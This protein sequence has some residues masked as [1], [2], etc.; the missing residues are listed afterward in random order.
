[1]LKL[2]TNKLFLVAIASSLIVGC[3]KTT[4]GDRHDGSPFFGVLMA[5]LFFVGLPLALLGVSIWW[6]YRH[7]WYYWRGNDVGTFSAR[8]LHQLYKEGKIDSQTPIRQVKDDGWNTGV[9]IEEAPR[10]I[11]WGVRFALL[12]ALFAFPV[13][14][15]VFGQVRGL[16]GNSRGLKLEHLLVSPGKYDLIALSGLTEEQLRQVALTRL[17]LEVGAAV[18]NPLSSGAER[19]GDR[20]DQQWDGFLERVDAARRRVWTIWALLVLIGG[21][22]GAA[23]AKGPVKVLKEGRVVTKNRGATPESK[24]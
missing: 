18:P 19:L 8:Q 17:G 14:L 11:R 21:S 20:M 24:P 16:D 15:L 22:I 2:Q 13:G 3:G 9:T 10:R 6:R 1:M 5:L 12:T 7:R 4:S 23:T